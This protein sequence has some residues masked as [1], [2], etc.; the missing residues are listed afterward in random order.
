MTHE[1]SQILHRDMNGYLF[2]NLSDEDDSQDRH[3]DM[4][5][6]YMKASGVSVPSLVK[7]QGL[8]GTGGLQSRGSRLVYQKPWQATLAGM[9]IGLESQ[10]LDMCKRIVSPLHQH[11]GWKLGAR[12]TRFFEEHIH[13]DEIRGQRVLPSS[14]SAA[15]R[16]KC[17]TRRWKL[18][19]RR[20]KNA[21][22]T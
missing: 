2:E 5:A 10:F 9:F 21:R 1:A 13:A 22:V 18:L 12:E 15:Q 17:K 11:Y 7:T 14:K 3:L 19:N 8:P 16:R 6:D 20:R 4:L